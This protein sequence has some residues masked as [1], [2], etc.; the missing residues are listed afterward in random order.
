LLE[1]L[2]LREG[3]MGTKEG[4]CEGDCGACTVAL[5]SLQDGQVVFEPVNACITLLGMVDGKEV[6]SVDDLAAED[7]ALH[8]VQSAMVRHD[9]SQCG[10]CTPGFVMS[11]FALYHSGEK[12]DRDVVN[13]WLAG[14][15][16]RC[17]GYRP[18]ADAALAA[19]DG[20]A[21]DHF[22]ARAAR[23]QGCLARLND[24]EDLFLGNEE[25]FFAAPASLDSLVRLCAKHP[26]ATLVA[27][28]TDVGI[29]VTK[30]LHDLPAVVHLGRV[31]ELQ[32][33]QQDEHQLLIGAAVTF[34]QAQVALGAIDPD[35]GELLRRLGARQVRA[36][37][38]VG[39][40]IAN[41]SPVGDSPPALIAL[42][43]SLD[44]RQRTVE[45][46]M[47]LED[48]FIDYGKQDRQ[49]G[50]FLVRVR[51]PT[52]RADERFRCYKISRRFDQDISAVLGAFK[53]EVLGTRVVSAR[54]AFGGMATTPRRAMLT[55]EA[56]CGVRLDRVDSWQDALRS[57]A[58]DYSPID[59]LRASARYRLDVA[60]ALLNKALMEIAGTDSAQTRL[61]GLREAQTGTIRGAA[62]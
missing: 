30:Q 1:Y 31:P 7:G 17:T 50:E 33:M 57:L 61:V 34:N 25:R 60:R 58:R 13:D 4:C 43:A 49:P 18:I 36:S 46:T 29:W 23:R 20:V 41:G 56:L 2:R 6:V 39:G 11:L 38:T 44:L 53:F 37:G 22:V 32:Q 5:G 54:V 3:A 14:N 10:F 42:G 19:C 59:D 48:F 35:L 51:I 16:C 26:H 27:G 47:P 12:P 62:L 8:P 24:G 9:G 52:L 55:E 45:R 15:L 21:A 40:N 28:A